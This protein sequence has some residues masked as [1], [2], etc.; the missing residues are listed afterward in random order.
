MSLTRNLSPRRAQTRSDEK[1]PD[2]TNLKDEK[3]CD[4]GSG[5][6]ELLYEV[7]HSR[8]HVTAGILSANFFDESA[9]GRLMRRLWWRQLDIEKDNGRTTAPH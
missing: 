3:D 7:P 5:N 4:C 2:R 8:N 6:A 9:G 1:E